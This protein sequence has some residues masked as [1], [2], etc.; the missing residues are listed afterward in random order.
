M[1]GDKD[2]SSSRDIR[3]VLNWLLTL[4]YTYKTS[5]IVIHHWNKSGKSERGGQRMLGSV[6]W[7]GWVESALYTK[8]INEQQHQIEVERE[9]RSFGKPSNVSMTFNFGQPGELNYQVIVSNDVKG[10]GD[11]VLQ[12][13]SDATRLTVDDVV[14]A[15]GLSSRQAKIRLDK[16]VK[17]GRATELNNIYT[18]KEED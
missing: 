13:L 16:L 10:A 3:P 18:Y 5:V 8:V 4:R 12:L 15:L 2:E 9:F 7:H 1:L 6:L 17:D 11:Q 14:T